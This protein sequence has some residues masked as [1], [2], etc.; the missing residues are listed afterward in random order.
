M[1]GF[2]KMCDAVTLD[3]ILESIREIAPAK[4]DE[5]VAA[6]KEAYDRTSEARI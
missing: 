4:A 3:S 2:A 5:N 1:G 6:A